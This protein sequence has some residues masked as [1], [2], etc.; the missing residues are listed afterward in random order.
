MGFLDHLMG[1]ARDAMQGHE[2]TLAP[3]LLSAL[4]GGESQAA[5]ANGLGALVG[6]F[7]KAGL[8]GIAQSWVSNQEPNQPVSP[9]QVQQALGD[10]HLSALAAKTGLPMATL[11]PT[12]AALLPKLVSGLTPNGQIPTTAESL[13]PGNPVAGGQNMEV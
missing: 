2:A 12:L 7:Q 5:Q 3:M 9:D 11:L 6:Q 4:G 10:D 1:A 13:T 8:G